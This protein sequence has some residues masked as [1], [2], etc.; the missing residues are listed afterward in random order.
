MSVQ[1]GHTVVPDDFRWEIQVFILFRVTAAVAVADLGER[2]FRR[3][4]ILAGFV[5]GRREDRVAVNLFTFFGEP[6][7]DRRAPASQDL[8]VGLVPP[9][10]AAVSWLVTQREALRQVCAGFFDRD[11]PAAVDFFAPIHDDVVPVECFAR[12]HIERPGQRVGVEI[13]IEQL[14]QCIDQRDLPD[15]VRRDV[16]KSDGRPFARMRHENG[17]ERRL[18]A[19][20]QLHAFVRSAEME[21]VEIAGVRWRCR[22]CRTSD[23]QFDVDLSGF[24]DIA[25][26]QRPV[27]GERQVGAARLDP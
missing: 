27:P 9:G 12:F 18:P 10:C 15:L 21:P 2:S 6:V 3:I 8:F 1:R 11:G 25:V 7:Q 20:C 24:G 19:E 14:F 22:R 26:V 13:E 23:R 16:G 4:G 17:P 5:Q